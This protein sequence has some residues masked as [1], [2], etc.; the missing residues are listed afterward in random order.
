MLK[1]ENLSDQLADILEKKIIRSEL[2]SGE[3]IYETQLAKEW[4]VSRSPVRDALRILVQK[5]LIEREPRGSY[6]VTEFSAT[7]I[8]DYYETIDLLF[9]Y[10]FA[11]A[12]RNASEERL[13][14]LSSAL[15]KMDESLAAA[16]ID[17]YLEG[18]FEFAQA[19]LKASGNPV[20]EQMALELMPTAQRIQWAS[21]TFQP[22]NHRL[23]VEYVRQSYEN[24]VKK[25]PQEA[26]KNFAAFALTHI[27]AAAASL[28]AA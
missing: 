14:E 23:V 21:L 27:N 12:A 11:R 7:S 28:R 16:D 20:V 5:R 19:I 6:R 2:A 25:N 10:S 3:V 9:Q 17:L 8:N 1:K 26:S 13:R 24:V 18:V 4:R 22:E 15:Q